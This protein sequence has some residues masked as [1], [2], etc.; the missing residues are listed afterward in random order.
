MRSRGDSASLALPI[1]IVVT[2][3][4]AFL[5]V[6]YRLSWQRDLGRIVQVPLRPLTFAGMAAADF[7]TPA[8]AAGGRAGVAS[9]IGEEEAEVIREELGRLRRLAVALQAE[10]AGLRE[11]LEGFTG[12]AGLGSRVDRP[13]ILR[14][15]T[16]VSRPPMDPDGLVTLLLREYQPGEELPYPAVIVDFRRLVVVGEVGPGAARGRELIVRPVTHTSVTTIQATVHPAGGGVGGGGAAGSERASVAERAAALDARLAG[17]GGGRGR[18]DGVPESVVVVADV[19]LEPVGDGT[20]SAYLREDDDV[21][22]GDRVLVNESRWP[23]VS[24]GFELG[25]VTSVRAD[26]TRPGRPRRIVVTPPMRLADG[27][28]WMFLADA[29]EEAGRGGPGAAGTDGGGGGPR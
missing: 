28:A 23:D 16:P 10:N 25:R 19:L 29:P 2:A 26:E 11:R 18:G 7:L 21:E 20:W 8:S 22:E 3:A 27:R 14:E 9:P 15:I 12:I 24:R 17:A 4:I 1:T 5:P 6:R 13:A